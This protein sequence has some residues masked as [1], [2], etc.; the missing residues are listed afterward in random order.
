MRR[1]GILC[2]L[3]FAL[4]L[5]RSAV[6]QA[7]AGPE[8]LPR[9]DGAPRAPT[10]DA[11]TAPPR[12]APNAETFRRGLSPHGEWVDSPKFG[13][14]WRPHAPPGWRPYFYGRWVWTADGWF[15]ASDEP[16][17]WA[18]YHYGRWGY[19]GVLGWFWVPGYE[20]APAWVTWRFGAGVVGWAPLFPG[21]SIFATVQPAFFIG[22]TFVPA[23][24]FVGFPVFRVA[25]APILVRR[26]FFVTNPVPPRR[27]FH[28]V[29]TPRWGGP[30]HRLVAAGSGRSIA[31]ARSA[32]GFLS[33][34]GAPGAG[35]AAR[36]RGA[37]APPPRGVHGGGLGL[38]RRFD[39]GFRGGPALP[40]G[41]SPTGGM[42]SRRW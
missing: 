5:P 3:V 27:I 31:N 28:G 21:I 36:P 1:S 2:A 26:F 17:A 13:R 38:A 23:V 25:F 8:T 6:A 24:R 4:T 12:S 41:R 20:W 42:H 33:R 18:T 9:D 15:W 32:P 29:W 16:W 30:P 19:D 37:M 11:E 35:F 34:S 10:G 40:M 7:Y 39:G 22:W 14:V